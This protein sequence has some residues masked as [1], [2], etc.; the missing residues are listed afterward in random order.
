MKIDNLEYCEIMQIKN[1]VSRCKEMKWNDLSKRI[2]KGTSWEE[3]K[4]LRNEYDD[5][6]NLFRAEGRYNSILEKIQKYETEIKDEI[7]SDGFNKMKCL[8]NE[9]KGVN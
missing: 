2:K 7:E 5:D 9:M 8:V 4:K 3:T 6:R 1:C